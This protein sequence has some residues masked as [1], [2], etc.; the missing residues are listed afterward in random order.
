MLSELTHMEA[1][2]DGGQTASAFLS[3]SISASVSTG[4]PEICKSPKK[5]KK[6]NSK[7]L[8]CGLILC[9]ASY[10]LSNHSQQIEATWLPL[11]RARALLRT[12]TFRD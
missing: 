10:F 5:K 8:R 12:T 11:S 1:G 9:N 2:N 7:A 6:A 4:F 3:N